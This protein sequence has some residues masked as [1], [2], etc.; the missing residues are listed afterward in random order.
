M[1]SK[2]PGEEGRDRFG[3]LSIGE[4]LAE[5]DSTH[6]EPVRRPELPRPGNKYAWAVGIV[7][8]M[9]LAVL[10]FAQTIP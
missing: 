7:A 1:T 10:L 5:R 3:D 2:R 4:R 8:V 9:G 6:P